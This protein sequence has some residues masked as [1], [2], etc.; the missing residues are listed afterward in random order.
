MLRHDDKTFH[1]MHGDFFS[2]LERSDQSPTCSLEAAVPEML[3]WP[4]QTYTKLFH[5]LSIYTAT[6]SVSH[7]NQGILPS[8]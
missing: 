2:S 1:T 5:A 3:P 7:H 8:S 6:V 4:S